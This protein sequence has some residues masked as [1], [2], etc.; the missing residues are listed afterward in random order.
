MLVYGADD[1]EDVHVDDFA[2][3]FVMFVVRMFGLLHCV[4]CNCRDRQQRHR[5]R[6]GR[7]CLVIEE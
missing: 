4:R 6:G 7:T 3:V 5:E 2:I 1:Y